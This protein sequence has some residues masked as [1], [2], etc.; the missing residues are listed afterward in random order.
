M[1]YASLKND[2]GVLAIVFDKDN[3]LTS[4]YETSVHPAAASGLAQALEVFGKDKVAILSNSAGTRDDPDYTD[5]IAIEQALGVAVIRHH[6]KKPG[7]LDEVLQHFQLTDPATLCIVGDRILTDIVFGNLY[8][9][10]T[11][12]TLPLCFGAA[13]SRDNW[14]AKLLRPIENSFVYG[15]WFGGRALL[16]RRLVHKF[17]PGEGRVPLIK[18]SSATAT[19]GRE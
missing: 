17:W 2:A 12:H 7:G 19:N 8:G 10:L 4:P 6:E 3:T 9:L 14:T 11:V 18:I 13:N 16:R 5:A 15:N 1:N